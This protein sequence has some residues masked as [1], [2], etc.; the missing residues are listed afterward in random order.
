MFEIRCDLSCKV[1][2]SYRSHL[3]TTVLIFGEG[4]GTPLLYIR[5]LENFSNLI[6][7][8]SHSQKTDQ[9][10]PWYDQLSRPA[11]MGL[12]HLLSLTAS[13]L[14]APRSNYMNDAWPSNTQPSWSLVSPFWSVYN[15]T[16]PPGA[17]GGL[18]ANLIK[19][20]EKNNVTQP[21]AGNWLSVHNIFF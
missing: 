13:V 14:S 7:A 11:Q 17:G 2:I 6:L 16:L 10:F 8:L 9:Q 4:S 21:N 12:H 20:T 1:I 18:L 15:I 3:G 5:W 19:R